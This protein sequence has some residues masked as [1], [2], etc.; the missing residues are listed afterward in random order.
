M[1]L[2]KVEE[3]RPPLRGNTVHIIT[4][5][6]SALQAAVKCNKTKNLGYLVDRIQDRVSAL[7]GRHI[8]VQIYWTAGHVNLA[9]NELADKLAKEAA[10]EAKTSPDLDYYIPVSEVKNLFRKA[11][12][13]RWQKRW[14]TGTDSRHTQ[15]LFPIV[16][17]GGYR[18]ICD[19]PTETKLLRLQLGTTLLKEHMHRIM[20]N[21]YDSPNCDCGT[22]RAT[23]EHYLLECP[24]HTRHRQILE[25]E[26]EIIFM[27]YTKLPKMDFSLQTILGKLSN[28]SWEDTTRLRRTV[29]NFIRSTNTDI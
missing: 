29:L 2:Q 21:Y 17:V 5:C 28:L 3:R 23:I 8:P 19:R 4:D 22:D 20:P 13:K 11:T 16:R 26:L 18:S 9:G 6:Q 1:A 10:L 14:N 7:R 24:T 25:N 12:T 15:A 27:K